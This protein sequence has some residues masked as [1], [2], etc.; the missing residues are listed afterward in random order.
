MGDHADRHTCRNLMADNIPPGSAR[1]STD[2]WQR[3]RG[4]PPG[5][6]TVAHAVRE[7][8]RDDEGDGQREV[9]GHSGEGAGA[10][11]RTYVR[12][13][14]GVHKQNL[15]LD[16]ATYEAMINAKR[17]TPD[18]IRRMCLGQLSAHTGYT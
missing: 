13:F 12:T 6:A 17:V 18:L 4:S 5:H 2:A 9:H 11:L 3:Y 8:A 7:W 10:A 16:V 1:L 14:R 15:H